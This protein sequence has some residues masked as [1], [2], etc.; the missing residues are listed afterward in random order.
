MARAGDETR[1]ADDDGADGGAETFAEA[2]G[3]AV[4]AF[5]V[6][7]QRPCARGDGFPDARPVEVHCYGWRLRARP[8]GDVLAV[9]EREDGAVEGVF[10]GDERGGTVVD[11]IIQHGVFLDILQG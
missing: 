1:G 7:F 11:V 8:L 9:R 6:V 4:E 3:D 10:Q 5:A 2:E